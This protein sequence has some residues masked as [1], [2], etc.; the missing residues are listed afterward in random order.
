[1]IY[2][3]VVLILNICV[4]YCIL[5]L[6]AVAL[7]RQT[8]FRRLLC[9]AAIGSVL[10]FLDFTPLATYSNHPIGK[11]VM[12]II[13]IA[14]AFGYKDSV[15]FFK[16]LCMFYFST[17]V[18]GGCVIGTHYL[19]QSSYPNST[20][21]LSSIGR[22]YGDPISWTYVF[23]AIPILMFYIKKQIQEISFTKLRYDKIVKIEVK[24]KNFVYHVNGLI[25]NGNQLQDPITGK[26]IIIIHA[27]CFDDGIPEEV[28][29]LAKMPL[30]EPTN[31]SDEWAARIR[32][33]PFQ[34]V[35]NQKGWLLT[36][37]SDEVSIYQA[38][39]EKIT[40]KNVMIGVNAFAFTSSEEYQ[41]ILH[42]KLL[43]G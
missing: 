21:S 41:C 27:N 12:S 33:V 37:R 19:L 25:D 24:I 17:F 8:S 31:I 6:T 1:M 43:V 4:D 30:H 29:E 15:T 28:L 7:K 22:I 18:F 11:M 36:I 32:I 16:N 5:L 10:V 14:V 26:P 35:G 38:N 40:C 9:G 39:K 23:V 20:Q 2:G 42:P 34:V 13:I 3:D